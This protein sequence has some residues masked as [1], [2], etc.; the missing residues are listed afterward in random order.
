MPSFLSWSPCK[1]PS[2]P[3][4]SPHFHHIVQSP[5]PPHTFPCSLVCPVVHTSSLTY[6][7][8]PVAAM[9]TYTAVYTVHVY[10]MACAWV[11][12][13][14]TGKTHRDGHHKSQ[15]PINIHHKPVQRLRPANHHDSSIPLIRAPSL[16][17][18]LVDVARK[19]HAETV[20]AIRQNNM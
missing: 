15:E 13:Q 18:A 2:L 16:A 12:A 5:H 10:T 4:S 14:D 8:V 17:S 3:L 1:P 11:A 19:T 7:N 6:T 20:T 9:H